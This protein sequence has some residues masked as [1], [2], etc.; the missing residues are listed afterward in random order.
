MED[1]SIT[2]SQI[3]ASGYKTDGSKSYKP[4]YGRLNN[5]P[6][7]EMGGV[8]CANNADAF[9]YL[10]IDLRTEKTLSG[11]STQGQGDEANWVAQYSIEHSKDGSNWVSFKE[12]GQKKVSSVSGT[13]SF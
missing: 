10:Q 7:G 13:L 6:S 9:K 3:T 8:W 4:E 1:R 5:R 12:F 2:N 11:I